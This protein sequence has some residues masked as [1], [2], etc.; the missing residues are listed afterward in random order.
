MYYFRITACLCESD[1]CNSYR[2]PDEP[3]VSSRPS[4]NT[5]KVT[6]IGDMT[7]LEVQTSSRSSSNTPKVTVIGDLTN[8]GVPL[9]QASP[10]LR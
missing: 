7:N 10:P 3:R 9:D 6:V 4:S 5:P 2:G 8:Q 1:L